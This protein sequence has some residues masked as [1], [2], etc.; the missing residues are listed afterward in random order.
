MA[1]DDKIWGNSDILSV[2]MSCYFLM[3]LLVFSLTNLMKFLFFKCTV[4]WSYLHISTSSWGTSTLCSSGINYLDF[5]HWNQLH[6]SFTKWL[7]EVCPCQRS[8]NLQSLRNRRWSGKLLVGDFLTAFVTC[9][10][11]TGLDCFTYPGLCLWT[12]SFLSCS[13][14]SLLGFGLSRLIFFFLISL[15]GMVKLRERLWPQQPCEDVGGKGHWALN[16]SLYFAFL[17]SWL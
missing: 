1:V 5:G 3:W 15:G 2:Y 4:Y 10:C 7:L 6:K 13:Q 14:T 17:T 12:T 16:L 9:S 11:Q 8:V